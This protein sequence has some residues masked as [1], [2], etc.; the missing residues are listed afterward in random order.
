MEETERLCDRV[1]IM[2]RGK[3]VAL[4]APEVLGFHVRGRVPAAERL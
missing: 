1:A 3:L 2:D 4:E